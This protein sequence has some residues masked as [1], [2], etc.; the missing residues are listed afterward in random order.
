MRE[1]GDTIIEVL[2]AMVVI[3]VTLGAAFSISNR[4]LLIGRAA[5]ER[6]EALKLAETSIELLR[7]AYKNNS[8]ANIRNTNAT[9]CIV[10]KNVAPGYIVAAAN[11]SDCRDLDASGNSGTGFYNMAVERYG[12]SYRVEFTWDRIAQATTETLV[13]WYRPGVL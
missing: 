11:S 6:S 8:P 10:P 1:R 13:L 2:F 3:G 5:Q 9:F 4:S 7:V 12:D